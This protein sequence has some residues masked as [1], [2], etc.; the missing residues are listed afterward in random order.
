MCELSGEI[1]A[2]HLHT[3]TAMIHTHLRDRGEE[4]QTDCLTV[5]AEHFKIS[6]VQENNLKCDLF[7]V[8]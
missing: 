4:K 2:A 8:C 5:H 1:N 6:G 7:L 3:P